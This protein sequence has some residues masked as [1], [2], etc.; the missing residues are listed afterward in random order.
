MHFT[1]H[2]LELKWRFF[3]ILLSTSIAFFISY[4]FSKELIYLVTSPLLEIQQ[5]DSSVVDKERFFIFTNMTEAFTTHIILSGYA[6][7]F[8]VVPLCLLQL[9]RFISPG[10]YPNEQKQLKLLFTLSPLCF[11]MGCFITYYLILP[12]AWQFLISF[13]TTNS[14]DIVH[15]HLE[16][17]ISEYLDLSTR[18]FFFV[19]FLFQYPILLGIL[20]QL[21]ILT[22]NWM[23]TKRKFVCL[24]SFI[25]AA[26]FSPPDVLSQMMIA[27][28]LLFF[29]EMALL[30]IILEGTYQN[31][32]LTRK[33]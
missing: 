28:P 8:S 24:L 31:L 9:W 20:I 33:I 12:T 29:Y 4:I 30:V 2:L 25:I 14:Q 22:K 21:N 1:K 32:D 26:L 15:I 3:Y 16:A 10:L 5:V 11:I 23:I 27:I 17:K 7:I 13:E 19:G 6:T 18:L